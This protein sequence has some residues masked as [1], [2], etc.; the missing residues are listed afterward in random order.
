MNLSSS[1]K[2][3]IPHETRQQWKRRIFA[4]QDVPARMENLKR[5]GFSPRGIIDGGA[6][7]GEWSKSAWDVWPVPTLLVEPQA[8]EQQ[9][10]EAVAKSVPGSEPV[11]CALGDRDGEIR[12]VN[13]ATNSRIVDSDEGVPV[14]LRRLDSLL[15]DRPGFHPDFVKLDLQGNELSALDGAGETIRKFE[16][17]LLEVSV[18][19]I[20]PVPVFHEVDLYMSEKGFTLYDLVP[21]YY[22]P[23]DGALWQVDVFYVRNDSKLLE[24]T[25]W[26]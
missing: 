13:E 7:R 1:L 16:V 17:L 8:S 12:F 21:Q 19:R 23:R 18:I 15:A 22:R 5:A 2:R 25:S 4:V 6:F 20:G 14:S 10:L 3:L 24:S 9:L 11:E 26:D